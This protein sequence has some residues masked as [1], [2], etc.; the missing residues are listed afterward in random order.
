M[1]T[2]MLFILIAMSLIEISLPASA[3]TWEERE[4]QQIIAE[5]A[6]NNE[7]S[8]RRSLMFES[9]SRSLAEHLGAQERTQPTEVPRFPSLLSDEQYSAT[10]RMQ[11]PDLRPEWPCR[12]RQYC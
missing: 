9:A 1:T 12:H 2:R 7:E 4:A 5:S 8:R 10:P 11:Q 3:Q 6:R